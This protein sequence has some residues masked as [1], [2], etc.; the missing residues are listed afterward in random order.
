VEYKQFTKV[1]RIKPFYCE[2]NPKEQ[3]LF[4]ET[5]AIQKNENKQIG[6]SSE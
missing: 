1:K 6:S 4:N 5:Q 2:R 3:K